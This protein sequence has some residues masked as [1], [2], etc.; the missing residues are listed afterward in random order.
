ML[1]THNMV[2]AALGTDGCEIHNLTILLLMAV[3][4]ACTPRL[5]YGYAE[6]RRSKVTILSHNVSAF[7]LYFNENTKW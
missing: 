4:L 7:S 1:P 2:S 6:T 3:N 5:W